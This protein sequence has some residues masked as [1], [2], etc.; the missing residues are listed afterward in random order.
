MSVHIC[1]CALYVDKE[2]PRKFCLFGADKYILIANSKVADM[3]VAL[4]MRRCALQ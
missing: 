1:K 4:C 3:L 2:K